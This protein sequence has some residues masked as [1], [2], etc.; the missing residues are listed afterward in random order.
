MNYF[1]REYR[2]TRLFC[3]I[4]M[5]MLFLFVWV[6]SKLIDYLSNFAYQTYP[7]CVK[8]YAH[9]AEDHASLIMLLFGNNVVNDYF[10]LET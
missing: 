5:N 9:F 3:M 4:S 7:F 1:Y 8:V 2:N 10:Y 6:V